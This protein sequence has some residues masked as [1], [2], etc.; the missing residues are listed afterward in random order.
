MA[1]SVKF[2]SFRPCTFGNL[3]PTPN[4]TEDEAIR[5]T[6]DADTSPRLKP[7]P[8]DLHDKELGILTSY[9]STLM[10]LEGG[11]MVTRHD[12]KT[13]GGHGYAGWPPIG[14]KEEILV[15]ND[16]IAEVEFV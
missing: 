2:L 15:G 12:P 14:I 10:W 13:E 9:R 11:I 4:V 3:R 7:I 8:E 5:I 16:W 1:T 6:L